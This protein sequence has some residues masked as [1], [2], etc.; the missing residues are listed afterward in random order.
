MKYASSVDDDSLA[1]HG[2][3]AAHGDYHVGA[4]VFI[5]GLLQERSGRG[6]FDLLGPQIG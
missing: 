1:G 3:G 5:G 2:L 4:I 6:P